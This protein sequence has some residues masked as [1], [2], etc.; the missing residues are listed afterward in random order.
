MGRSVITT[1]KDEPMTEE[2]AVQATLEVTPIEVKEDLM[3]RVSKVKLTSAHKA[4]KSDNQ[5]ILEVGL[6]PSAAFWPS[7]DSVWRSC[8]YNSNLAKGM[9]E[10]LKCAA[11]TVA[12]APAFQNL[13][14]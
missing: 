5:K 7:N 12:L 9:F 11:Y 14:S 1:R 3:S 13:Y 10:L 2:A 6:I 8:P 4:E